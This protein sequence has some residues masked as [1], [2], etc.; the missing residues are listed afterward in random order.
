[1]KT[2]KTTLADNVITELDG[3]VVWLW[4]GL[5]RRWATTSRIKPVI[6]QEGCRLRMAGDWR[7][8]TDEDDPSDFSEIAVANQDVAEERKFIITGIDMG[9]FATP[10]MAAE[11]KRRIEKEMPDYVP[12]NCLPQAN[13]AESGAS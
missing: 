1:M 8:K 3:W 5:I 9:T 7:Y 2:S 12:Q 10:E 13:V 11:A 6:V 4:P